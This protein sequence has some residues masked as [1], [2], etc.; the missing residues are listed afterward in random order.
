MCGILRQISYDFKSKTHSRIHQ[1]IADSNCYLL[2]LATGNGLSPF[3]IS[4]HISDFSICILAP[5]Q[6]FWHQK[7][8]LIINSIHIRAESMNTK[9]KHCHWIIGSILTLFPNTFNMPP[10]MPGQYLNSQSTPKTT[11]HKLSHKISQ[12]VLIHLTLPPVYYK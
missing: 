3:L 12:P 4:R 2:K 11:P 1:P 9:W 8:P 5:Y 10:R 7:A 6:Q